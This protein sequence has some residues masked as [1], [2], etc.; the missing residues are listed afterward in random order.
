MI[1]GD[2]VEVPVKKKA[3]RPKKIEE[4]EDAKVVKNRVKPKDRPKGKVVG[5]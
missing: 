2:E 1:D 3:G 5:K 4:D